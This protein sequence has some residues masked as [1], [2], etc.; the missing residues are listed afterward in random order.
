MS[1]II[2][3]LSEIC[4]IWRFH[5]LLKSKVK[6]DSKRI[7]SSHVKNGSV[8]YRFEIN[9]DWVVMPHYHQ[10]KN[11][12]TNKKQQQKQNKHNNFLTALS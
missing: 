7:I 8:Q 6:A 4:S 3:T 9:T 1:C 5:A 10:I 12:Q 11:K 2:L